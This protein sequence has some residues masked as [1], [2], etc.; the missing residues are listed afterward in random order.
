MNS[1]T[2]LTVGIHILCLLAWGDGQRMTSE[3]IAGSVNTNPVVIRR[4]L[5][6]LRRAGFV[7]S[8]NGAGGGWELVRPADQITLRDVFNATGPTPLVSLHR[9]DPNPECPVGASIQRILGV[10]YKRAE[11]AYAKSLE[12]T[13][14]A[15]L[16][17]AI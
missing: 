15:D 7:R 17:K 6:R 13:T 11:D 5:S 2:Q 4:Q 9:G 10:H 8:R 3:F 16:L 14:I 1:N 12:K